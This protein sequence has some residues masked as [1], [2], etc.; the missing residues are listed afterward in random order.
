MESQYIFEARPGS[1][2]GPIDLSHITPETLPTILQ[3]ICDEIQGL[4]T[5][6]AQAEKTRQQDYDKIIKALEDV[7]ACNS[8][9]I[10]EYSTDADNLKTFM[11]LCKF[12]ID[13]PWF[14]ALFII[15]AF[16]VTD[17]IMRA[18]YWEIWPK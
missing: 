18:I 3:R 11:K 7:K 10:T 12:A 14:A 5:D 17:F 8:K 6:F 9:E 2:V 1:L 13:H 15:M 16:G 4:K